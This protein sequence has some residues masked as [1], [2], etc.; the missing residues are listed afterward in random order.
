MRHDE[1]EQPGGEGS[2]GG[3]AWGGSHEDASPAGA[4]WT[5]ERER[6]WMTALALAGVE[7]AQLL[8]LQRVQ[9]DATPTDA[10]TLQV[11]QTLA[12][13]NHPAACRMVARAYLAGQVVPSDAV[14]GW[15]WMKKAAD[16]SDPEAMMQWALEHLL[17]DVP[18]GE[19]RPVDY[20]YRAAVNLQ[21]DAALMLA[22]MQL[23]QVPQTAAHRAEAYAWLTVGAMRDH[24]WSLYD[25]WRL[26]GMADDV[27]SDETWRTHWLRRAAELGLPVAQRLWG[28]TLWQQADSAAA[29]IEAEGWLHRAASGGDPEAAY[30]LGAIMVHEH[31]P[32]DVSLGWTLTAARGGHQEAQWEVGRTLAD[33]PKG[34]R[35][36]SE[37]AAWLS[38]AVVPSD[39]RDG[40]VGN[41]ALERLE[42]LHGELTDAQRAEVLD[43]LSDDT[44]ADARRVFA[45]VCDLATQLRTSGGAA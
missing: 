9:A 2:E 3:G 34:P 28:S 29:R 17:R 15:A 5:I 11:C 24:A 4:P 18:E 40:A 16:L 6:A 30:L 35:R 37:A 25:L 8:V 1:D 12:E 31:R 22:R 39:Q 23:A 41:Q 21:P 26:S 32:R 38:R 43:L 13:T 20:L 14:A 27:P 44:D 36:L 33:E 7:P 42:Q 19:T 10:Q 45:G